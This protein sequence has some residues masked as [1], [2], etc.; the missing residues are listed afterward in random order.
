MFNAMVNEYCCTIRSTNLCDW[1]SL[2]KFYTIELQV[3][4]ALFIC[5]IFY[6]SGS[7]RQFV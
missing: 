2:F 1:R 5:G 7:V 4:V 3:I 6:E